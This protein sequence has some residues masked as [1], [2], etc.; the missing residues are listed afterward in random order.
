MSKTTSSAT[1]VYALVLRRFG[2]SKVSMDRQSLPKI[3]VALQSSAIPAFHRT[4]SST[5]DLPGKK[6]CSPDQTE[7]MKGMLSNL[8]FLQNR[9][10]FAQES[11]LDDKTTIVFFEP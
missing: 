4:K 11:P 1:P 8:S 5:V 6:A 10:R 2:T 7:S 3:N 9:K